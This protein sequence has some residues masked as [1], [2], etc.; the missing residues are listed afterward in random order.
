MIF[1]SAFAKHQD[2]K[3]Q[4]KITAPFFGHRI[5]GMYFFGINKSQGTSLQCRLLSRNFILNLATIQ[6]TNTERR[7]NMGF[8]F[9]FASCRIATFHK[10]QTLIF[11]KV[12]S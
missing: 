8:I 12:L 5:A 6:R 9:T 11:E 4:H 1:Y 7:M 2:N 10:G 3:I